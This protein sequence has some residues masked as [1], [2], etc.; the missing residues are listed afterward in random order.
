MLHHPLLFPLSPLSCGRAEEGV[1]G[2]TEVPPYFHDWKT[3]QCTESWDDDS[4]TWMRPPFLFNVNPPY[5]SPLFCTRCD[6]RS[7][8]SSWYAHLQ[9]LEE[10]ERPE[11]GTRA[12]QVSMCMGLCA[13]A[14]FSSILILLTFCSLHATHIHTHLPTFLS[15]SPQNVKA[16]SSIPD[17]RLPTS[18]GEPLSR[19]VQY[20][21]AKAERTF[22]QTAA[23]RDSPTQTGH[24]PMPP[25][26]GRGKGRGVLRLANGSSSHQE[27]CECV[28]VCV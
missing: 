8:S 17:A 26:L 4:E 15:R 12:R 27:P 2:N 21:L 10:E 24:A 5:P 18:S 1:K 11:E 7:P 9:L 22:Q 6:L 28:C 16:V 14:L 13:L 25:G 23:M 20:S 3:P 19:M